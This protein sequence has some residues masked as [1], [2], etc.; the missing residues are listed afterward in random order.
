MTVNVPL[1][2]PSEVGSAEKVI[3]ESTV[4]KVAQGARGA[5][6][7]TMPKNWNRR[8]KHNRDKIKTGNIF[9]LAEVVRNLAAATSE[10]ASPPARSR[11]SSRRRRSSSP[12]SCT[13]RMHDEEEGRGSGS[14]T[15]SKARARRSRSRRATPK[16]RRNRECVT[17]RASL[18]GRGPPGPL[19]AAAG[20]LRASDSVSTAQ[21]RSQPSGVAPCWP[22]AL[23]TA[24][25]ARE[26]DRRDRRQ[27]AL[28]GL[29]GAVD[30]ARRGASPSEDSLRA[31]RE[32]QP[33]TAS[34]AA[35]LFEV[36]IGAL[37]VLV[38]DA[39]RPLVTDAVIERL[40]GALGEGFD[41]AVPAGSGRGYPQTRPRRRG[42]GEI[43]DRDGLVAAQT[44]QAFAPSLRRAFSGD[45]SE[46]TD[47]A[48]RRTQRAVASPS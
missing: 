3:N 26:L 16:G 12:S 46:A 29:G 15:C 21:R 18:R 1:T 39:A 25:S 31:S 30:P 6:T 37:V 7:T 47:C 2:T 22:R 42:H 48:S 19:I 17:A 28:P 24:R 45:L 14:T 41:G 36:P 9:E 33:G 20:C 23:E 27:A 4:K 10:R 11:C 43:V 34:V 32:V 44:L 13:R 5:T 38:H 40:I 8:F 35:A